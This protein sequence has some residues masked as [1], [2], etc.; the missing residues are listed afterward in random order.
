MVTAMTNAELSRALQEVKVL[1]GFIPI[2]ISC[3][4]ICDD[5]GFWQQFESYIQKRS[6]ALFSHGVCPDCYQIL[7]DK[8]LSG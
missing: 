8:Y 4:N 5:K 2:C 3:K 1:R 6:E 7:S